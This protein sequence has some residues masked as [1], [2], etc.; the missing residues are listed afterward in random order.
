MFTSGYVNIWY[1]AT[2]HIVIWFVI[3]QEK[4][5][6]HS[7]YIQPSRAIKYLSRSQKLIQNSDK[8]EQMFQLQMQGK[9]VR[10]RLIWAFTHH[11]VAGII[12]SCQR[13]LSLGGNKIL[14]I[15]Q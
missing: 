4:K 3:C 7:K 2:S 13:G 15:P 9:Q 6:G 11:Q 12:P 5:C 8:T 14:P 1:V 10:K